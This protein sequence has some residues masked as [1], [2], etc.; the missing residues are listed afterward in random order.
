MAK[1]GAFESIMNGLT[2]SFE[3]AKGDTSKARKMCI[4]VAELPSYYDKEIKKNSEDLNL[5]R[6]RFAFVLGGF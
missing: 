2:E 3:Y 4:T 5:T 6:N 1:K